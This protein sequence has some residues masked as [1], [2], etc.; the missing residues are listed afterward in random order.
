M[1]SSESRE[2][3]IKG[4]RMS[5]EWFTDFAGLRPRP[6]HALVAKPDATIPELH[7]ALCDAVVEMRAHARKLEDGGFS[8]CATELAETCREFPE[9]L[10]AYNTK[11]REAENAT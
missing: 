1:T 3:L 4:L 10:Q 5:Q 9:L 2:V 8:L 6:Y 7:A 11:C